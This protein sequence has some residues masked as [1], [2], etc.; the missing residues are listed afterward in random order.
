MAE[1]PFRIDVV[2]E[3]MSHEM[4]LADIREAF[5]RAGFDV[6]P[7]EWK[8]LGS[9]AAPWVISVS[10][11]APIATFFT[12]FA[13]K[14]AEDAYEPVKQWVKDLWALR[15]GSVVLEDFEKTSLVLSKDLPEAA[16]DAL[17]DIDWFEV[18]GDYLVWNE[19]KNEWLDPRRTGMP[20]RLP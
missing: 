2:V 8:G 11:G 20:H 16:L 5:A 15:P 17:R 4:E 10:L 13:S 18:R 9:G 3:P 12:T 6:Q 7:E 14:A 19:K 1:P